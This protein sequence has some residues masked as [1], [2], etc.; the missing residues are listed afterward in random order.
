SRR[1]TTV[2]TPLIVRRLVLR[3]DGEIVPAGH[4][5]VSRGRLPRNL[6]RS[7]PV[8][9]LTPDRST[10]HHPPA[11]DIRWRQQW[12]PASLRLTTWPWRVA[13]LAGSR[14]TTGMPS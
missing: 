3:K 12:R 13:S 11:A 5:A 8:S 9:S 6:D 14:S 2:L 1:L 4:A 7:F 10:P